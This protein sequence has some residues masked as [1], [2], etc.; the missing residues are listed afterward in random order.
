MIRLSIAFIFVLLCAFDTVR[1][2]KD[3]WLSPN[4]YLGQKPPGD[5]PVPFAPDLL[6]DTDGAFALDRT[7]FSPDGKS[8]YYCTNK[9]WFKDSASNIKT[10]SWKNGKWEGPVILNEHYYAPTLSPDGNILF[11][12]GGGAF[13]GVSRSLK[14]STGWSHP[15][16]Y[17][18][19]AYELYDYIPVTSGIAYAGSSGLFGKPHVWNTFDICKYRIAGKDTSITSLGIPLNTPGFD[20][21]FFIS[22][23]ES[24]II[25][26]AKEQPDFEC[27]LYISYHKKDGSWTNPK[28]L[29]PL[30]NNGMA[31]RWGEY[32]PPGNKYLFFSYGHNEKD[33]GIYW[34]RFDNLLAKLRHTNFDPYVKTPLKDQSVISGKPFSVT[35]PAAAF[36]DDDGI[37]TLR[38]SV[39]TKDGGALPPWIRFDTV[40]RRLW[41]NAPGPTELLLRVTVTDT[42][43][44]VAF[45]DFSLLVKDADRK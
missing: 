45:N 16:L 2:Q 14:T 31:H 19:H 18:H 32:V 41:G 35:L 34:V 7:A 10:Y 42:A 29:G 28:S 40:K 22:A 17:L 38:W 6:K 4:A 3:F 11:F 39:R 8:F 44:A 13:G 20:G 43:G 15:E 23:D 24:F 5:T 21:D 26:S 9:A 12:M 30:I 37:Q 36:Y 1:A 25:I 27:E 33:C